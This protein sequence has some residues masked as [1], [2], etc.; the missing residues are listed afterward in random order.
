MSVCPMTCHQ[1]NFFFGYFG[2]NFRGEVEL[3]VMKSCMLDLHKR[4]IIVEGRVS[5]VF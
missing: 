4:F 1:D 5:I 3:Q 2:L